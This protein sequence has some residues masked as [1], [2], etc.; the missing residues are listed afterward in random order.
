MPKNSSL[1]TAVKKIKSVKV[2]G[3]KEIA[4]Y[5]LKFLRKLGK[6]RGFGKEFS[7]A[8]KKLEDTRPTAVV[9]HNCLEIIDKEKNLESI[10]SLL[11]KLELAN[12]KIAES[13]ANLFR[14]K[15]YS[16]LTHCHSSEAL[17]V[18][19]ELKKRGKKIS[20][21]STET[22]PLEQGVKTAKELTKEGIKVTLIVD[23][24]VANFMPK[25]DMVIVGT[26]AMRREGIVNKIGTCLY[27]ESAE[28]HGKP[29]FV[30]GSTL[31]LDRRKNF[32]IEYRSPKEVRRELTKRYGLAG[33]NIENPAFDITPW[34]F[35]SRVITESGAYT[36]TQIK[37]ML[38]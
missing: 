4:V 16:I 9:L 32:E 34:R 35:V 22:D 36:P 26:D 17:A 5:S 6:E 29:F 27:A 11:E 10:D 33:V 3:A 12:D 8:A 25:I 1:S 24:A 37:R 15:N 19:K 13:G 7:H 20:V 30:V 38:K 31:K 21:I 28:E 2:Q 18:I 23:S 14:K